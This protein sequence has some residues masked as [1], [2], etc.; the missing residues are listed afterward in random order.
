MFSFFHAGIELILYNDLM[1]GVQ[2]VHACSNVG[3]SV[4][5]Y[6]SNIVKVWHSSYMFYLVQISLL[7]N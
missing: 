5:F 7:T 3:K 2:P 1:D 6:P 4:V